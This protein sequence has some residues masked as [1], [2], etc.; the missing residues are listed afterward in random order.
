MID[1]T[2]F[3]KRITAIQAPAVTTVRNGKIA[4]GQNGDLVSGVREGIPTAES[5][6]TVTF[7]GIVYPWHLDHMQHMNV[8]H[9]VSM[10]DQSS[11]I[12]LAM[13]GLDSRYFREHHSGMAALEQT[14]QYKSELRCGEMFEIRSALVEVREKTMRVQH[15]MYK[16]ETGMLAASTSI[17][18][19]YIDTETRK[20]SP[21]PV[22]IRERAVTLIASNTNFDDSFDRRSICTA[23]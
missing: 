2:Y 18:G 4:G 14:T 13:V 7:R 11:W 23:P 22:E 15:N 12:F 17:V 10:F 9:Y 20:S 19:V 3:A 6:F 8:Q 16:I 5:L 21:L 1:I